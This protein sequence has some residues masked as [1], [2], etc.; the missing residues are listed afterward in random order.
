MSRPVRN[1]KTKTKKIAFIKHLYSEQDYYIFPLCHF[2]LPSNGK[3]ASRLTLSVS[4]C[5]ILQTQ[6]MLEFEGIKIKWCHC[7]INVH[8]YHQV[9]VRCSNQK[10]QIY[11]IWKIGINRHWKF[12]LY[13]ISLI[14]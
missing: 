2:I 7:C 12:M 13:F 1:V 3:C 9:V 4:V 6:K 14:W 11:W 5:K 8:L 10:W